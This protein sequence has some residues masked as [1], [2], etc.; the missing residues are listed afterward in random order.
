MK[1]SAIST[2]LFAVVAIAVPVNVNMHSPVRH[3]ST[4]IKHREWHTHLTRHLEANKAV[5]LPSYDP[6]DVDRLEAERK[7]RFFAGRYAGTENEE[8]AMPF[9]TGRNG[10]P[11]AGVRDTL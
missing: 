3:R 7:E 8:L 4:A 9:T 5:E 10:V 11:Y 1:L 2:L 6:D